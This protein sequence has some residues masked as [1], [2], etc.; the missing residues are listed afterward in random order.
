MHLLNDRLDDAPPSSV[1]VLFVDLDHF[2]IVNDSLGH[3]VGDQ[4]LSDRGRAAAQRASATTT[5]SPGSAA[6][7]SSS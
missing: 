6:T 4:L 2:K 7:S 3:E 5:C 1:A